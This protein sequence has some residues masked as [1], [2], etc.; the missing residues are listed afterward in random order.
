MP[1]AHK[2]IQKC[3]ASS[4]CPGLREELLHLVSYRRGVPCGSRSL[5]W[6][7]FPK[8]RGPG[9]LW[10]DTDVRLCCTGAAC[11]AALCLDRMGPFTKIGGSDGLWC[12]ADVRLYCTGVRRRAALRCLNGRLD[13]W[14]GDPDCAGSARFSYTTKGR[15]LHPFLFAAFKPARPPRAPNSA[16][17]SRPS[18][19]AR[20]A[21]S[22]CA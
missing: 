6:T 15:D 18:R 19:R 3:V 17:S 21:P 13:Q 22:S 8:N 16:G 11:R 12:C 1:A 4:Y 9:R 20:P 10:R 7:P 5:G 2:S 14:T